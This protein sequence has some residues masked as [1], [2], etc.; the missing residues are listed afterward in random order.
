MLA[1]EIGGQDP[2][3]VALAQE[4]RQRMWTRYNQDLGKAVVAYF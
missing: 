1:L 2:V 4:G 3:T